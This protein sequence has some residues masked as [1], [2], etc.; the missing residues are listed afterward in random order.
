[1]LIFLLQVGAHYRRDDGV[2]GGG[3]D[4]LAVPPGPQESLAHSPAGR[5][6]LVPHEEG[7]RHA[8]GGGPGG[9]G[10]LAGGQQVHGP[11]GGS[12]GP[13][14]LSEGGPHRV[15]PLSDSRQAGGVSG[16]QE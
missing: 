2:G 6:V 8:G 7:L 10:L 11:R 16:Q 13:G 9:E 5:R 15:F 1:M 14:R 12:P 3:Q 4:Q